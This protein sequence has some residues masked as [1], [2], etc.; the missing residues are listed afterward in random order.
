MQELEKTATEWIAAK[1]AKDETRCLEIERAL[2]P[3]SAKVL[4]IL[5][6]A[7]VPADQDSE[8]PNAGVTARDLPLTPVAWV[9]EAF[10]GYVGQLLAESLSDRLNDVQVDI[11]MMVN[12]STVIEALSDTLGDEV[13]P[14][15]RAFADYINGQ[16]PTYTSGCPRNDPVKV[17]CPMIS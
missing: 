12:Q 2:M 17:N 11:G 9:E 16:C 8:L 4:F 14:V 13:W 6:S 5:E 7:L 10:P 15:V 1:L 3:E